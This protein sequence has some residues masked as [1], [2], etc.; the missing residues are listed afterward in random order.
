MNPKH[1]PQR[2]NIKRL[3]EILGFKIPLDGLL[4]MLFRRPCIDVIAL[5]KKLM[6]RYDYEGSMNDFILK[7]FGT[8]AQEIMDELLKFPD[9]N[10]DL[11]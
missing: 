6:A 1:S 2:Q 9:E 7:Q 5:D 10:K 11:P 3:A 4:M 8:E